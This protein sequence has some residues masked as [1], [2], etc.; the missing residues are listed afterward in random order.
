MSAGDL[1]Q[2]MR[3]NQIFQGLDEATLTEAFDRAHLRSVDA[4]D[5]FAHQGDPALAFHILTQGRVKLVQV[6]P[7]GHGILTRFVRPGQEFG[8]IAMLSGFEQPMSAQAIDDCQMLVWAGE[9]MAQMIEQHTQIA[10]NAMRILVT[11]N[12]YLQRRYQELLT[13]SVEQRL[14]QAVLNLLPTVGREVDNGILIDMP[15]T[16]EDLAELTGT[17]IYSVSRI[18][19]RWERAGIVV[20][21]RRQIVVCLPQALEPIAA[22]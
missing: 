17:T 14:A 1:Q 22:P 2:L 7:D 4:G 9:V 10:F 5:V 15:L 21:R 18:L 13:E 16:E 11:R 3:Q 8:V 19:N 20:A 6:A 12:L